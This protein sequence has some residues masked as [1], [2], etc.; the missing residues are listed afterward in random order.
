MS[1]NGLI[2]NSLKSEVGFVFGSAKATRYDGS[3]RS[4]G[5]ADRRS[6]GSKITGWIILQRRFLTIAVSSI[7]SSTGPIFIRMVASLVL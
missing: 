6:L 3:A 1:E 4:L 2:E 7:L 5:I